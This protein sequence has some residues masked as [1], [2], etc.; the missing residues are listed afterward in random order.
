MDDDGDIGEMDVGF[1][2]CEVDVDFM[3]ILTVDYMQYKYINNNVW[4]KI[5]ISC[6]PT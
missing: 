2:C 1:L 3:L 6:S 4:S 5:I